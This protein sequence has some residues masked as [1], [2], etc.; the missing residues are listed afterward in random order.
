MEPGRRDKTV[1]TVKDAGIGALA[2]AALGAAGG[3]IAGGGH[4]PGKGAAIG[5][6]VGAGIEDWRPM[7]FSGGGF[8]IRRSCDEVVANGDS[9]LVAPKASSEGWSPAR[10]LASRLTRVDSA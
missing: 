4:G 10:I 6:L 9:R 3:A 5:G 1:D 8:Q 2:G 7:V